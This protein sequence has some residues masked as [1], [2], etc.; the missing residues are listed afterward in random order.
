MCLVCWRIERKPESRSAVSRGDDSG[1]WGRTGS[2][3]GSSEP[4]GIMRIW[5]FNPSETETR[6]RMS[7]REVISSDLGFN[8][9]SGHCVENSLWKAGEEVEGPVS[10]PLQG[11]GW[12]M[13]VAQTK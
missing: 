5:V 3:V 4:H 12:Q 2:G 10:R 6:C 9:S 13:M 1:R 11:S 7:H 8:N